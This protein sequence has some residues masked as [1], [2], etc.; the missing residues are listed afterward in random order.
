MSVAATTADKRIEKIVVLGGGSAGLL[1]AVTLKRRLPDLQVTLV[2]SSKIPIIGVG[3]GTTFTMPIF[4]HGYLG[5]DPTRFHQEVRPTY[6][7]GIRFLW[8]PRP[9]FHYAFTNQLDWRHGD[10][11]KPNGFY[12][13]EDFDYADGNG[14]LMGH[15]R[16][17][18]RQ[19]NG[20]GPVV[21]T[22]V[23]YHLE[24]ALF[25]AYLEKLTRELGVDIVDAEVGDVERDENQVTGLQLKDGSKIEA[26]FFIDCSGFRSVLLGEAM[27]EP[28]T[29][30]SSSLFCD[31]ALAGG[32]ERSDETLLPYTTAETMDSGWCWQI[33]HERVINRG[34]V[35]S[36]SAI[37][38]DKAEEEFRKKNP[39]AEDARVIKFDTGCRRNTWAGNVVGLGN[40]AG[41][42][43]PL[44]ATN[45]AVICDHIAKLVVTLRD[46]NMTVN[47]LSR[48]YYNRYTSRMWQG[49]RRFLAM[50]YRF[51]TR[52]DTKFWKAC[53]EDTDLAGGEEIVS[54]YQACGPSLLWANEAM[55]A[56][57]PFS[58]EGYLAMLV[59]QK[60]PHR[61]SYKPDEQE[62]GRWQKFMGGLNQSASQALTMSEALSMIRSP[63][64]EWQPDFYQRAN[65]W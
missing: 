12:C 18:M 44:E 48:D 41:F 58:W 59:G 54:Y 63:N 31:R 19:Q 39:K 32:W 56:D 16:A 26:D 15:D 10:L 7:L 3:E 4:L 27:G 53:Q 42:V 6:K 28:H 30:F 36:S 46:D 21:T 55:G 5:I 51:N 11:S 52:L 37:S 22:S 9:R 50:H 25:I 2:H 34:Y 20:A 62:M 17:F 65:R 35:Y 61:N 23:A 60:V 57:D 14:A 33:E 43:E 47:A 40:S 45:L 13:F 38:D 29:S 8:G 1:S 24:N 49:I 64:W